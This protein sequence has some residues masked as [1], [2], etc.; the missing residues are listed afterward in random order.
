MFVAQDLLK[1]GSITEKPPPPDG[2]R[3]AHSHPRS[4]YISSTRLCRKV[5]RLVFAGMVGGGRRDS[6]FAVS[7]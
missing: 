4:H 6:A 5:Y 1:Q 7:Q 3:L 2:G